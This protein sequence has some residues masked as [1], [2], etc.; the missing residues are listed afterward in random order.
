M[1]GKKDWRVAGTLAL[2]GCL[3]GLVVSQPL[4]AQISRQSPLNESPLRPRG[5]NVIPVY[6][7]WFENSD[8]SYQ[9]CF[10]YFNLN[11]EQSLDIPLGPL[12]RIEP[13]EFDGLQPTHF[14]PVPSPELTARYRHHWC[15]FSV[16]VPDDFGTRDVVW[17]LTSQGDEITIPGWI[18]P[19]YILDEPTSSGRGASAPFLRLEEDGPELQGRTGLWA[20]PRTVQANEPLDLTSWIRHAEPG[21][22]LGWTKHQGPGEVTFSEAEIRLEEAAE[23]AA[24]TTAT[25]DQPGSYVVRVQVINDTESSRNPTYGFEFHCC[26][27][28]GYVR[29]EVVE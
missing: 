25:F 20:G 24:T 26:W 13:S 7:G 15:V 3:V 6:D 5:Q 17:S 21:T 12:N 19:E 22:W 11:T 23:G 28:N 14:D 9:L 8:G 16:N 1:D 10:G 2:A 4:A 27:T 29:V 18:L